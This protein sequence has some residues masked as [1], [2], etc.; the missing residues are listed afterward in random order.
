MQPD[1]VNKQFSQSTDPVK[2]TSG[3]GSPSDDSGI[4]TESLLTLH[5]W[6]ELKQIGGHHGKGIRFAPGE[7]T[8]DILRDLDQI[9]LIAL[10]SESYTDGRI[11][12]IATELRV[13]HGY[14]NELR[15]IGST[16]DN[17]NLL[18]QCGFDSVEFEE[19]AVKN[20]ST[21]LAQN[22]ISRLHSL[23]SQTPI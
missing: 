5:V 13:R 10:E 17:L 8:D 21:V 12:S 15:A 6:N 9:P 22:P 20:I 3:I 18:M 7:E 2:N 4:D 23:Y 19:G 14:K 16:P 11:Y 1:I